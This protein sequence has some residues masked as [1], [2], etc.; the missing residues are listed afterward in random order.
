MAK[1]TTKEVKRVR[2]S[3]E[4]VKA[5]LS[6]YAKEHDL[7]GKELDDAIRRC[8]ATRWAALERN[9]AKLRAK[10]VKR[11]AHKTASKPKLKKAA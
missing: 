2:M 6:K 3:P 7:R 1:N 9:V 4:Q 11:V 8:A 5:Y 10:P